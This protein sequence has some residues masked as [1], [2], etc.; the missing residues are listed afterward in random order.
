[1]A[2]FPS[3]IEILVWLFQCLCETTLVGTEGVIL[4]CRPSRLPERHSRLRQKVN[5]TQHAKANDNRKPCI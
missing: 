1:M 5:K 2:V 4:N 3:Y